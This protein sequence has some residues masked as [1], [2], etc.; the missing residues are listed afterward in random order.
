MLVLKTGTD[1]IEIQ[2]LR[3]Y[4]AGSP[5]RWQRFVERIYTPREQ[6]ESNGSDE[7]L[8]GRFA[9]KEAVAKA[10][11]CGIGLVSWQEIEVLRGPAGEPL[12][13]LHG[14]AAQLAH[15]LGLQQWSVSISHTRTYALALAVALGE[16]A[17][18]PP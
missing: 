8:A 18:N 6:T 7:S 17:G 15:S 9:A 13:T 1:L 3:D 10:L 12:L 14:K 5:G 4:R 11:G 2:R 16:T